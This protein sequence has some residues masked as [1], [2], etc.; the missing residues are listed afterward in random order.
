MSKFIIATGGTGGHI[1]PSMSLLE[2]LQLRK[3]NVLIIADQRFLQFKNQI[4][5]N[6]KYKIIQT[7]SFSGNIF[8]RIQSAFKIFIGVIQAL[9]IIYRYKPKMVLSFG[10]YISFPTMIAA[11]ILRIPLLIHEQNSVI[12]KANR[13]LIKKASLVSIAFKNTKGLKNVIRDKICFTGNPVS[14]S[15]IKLRKEKYPIITSSSTIKLLVLGGSQGARILSNVVP[16][17][18]VTLDSNLKNRLEIFQQCRKEDLQ[19]VK[20]KYDKNGIKSQTAVFFD[21]IPK[22]LAMSNFVICRSG[23][24]TISELTASG[25]PAILIPL[26][27]AADNHQYFNAR[28]LSDKNA[29]WIIEEKDFNSSNLAALIKALLQDPNLL[30]DAAANMRS[31]FIDF[32]DQLLERIEEF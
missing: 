30:R 13:I 19:K 24:A 2:K 4:P 27:I 14:Q 26:K 1:F 3:H 6:A 18:I 32:S 5:K 23:A 21:D 16:D 29:A 10:G 28:S 8:F 25:R 17:A 31:Q 12:G 11:L 9:V 22:K 20:N 15:L 7:S